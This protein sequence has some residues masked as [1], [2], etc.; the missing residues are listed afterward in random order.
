M[1]LEP[2]PSRLLT[3]ALRAGNAHPGVCR[4]VEWSCAGGCE[5]VSFL[6]LQGLGSRDWKSPLRGKWCLWTQRNTWTWQ[7]VTFPKRHFELPVLK[8]NYFLVVTSISFPWNTVKG[9]PAAPREHL[10][11]LCERESAQSSSW[12][13][14]SANETRRLVWL[15][16][17]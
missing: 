2:S 5:G 14:K 11:C 15:L 4:Q 8:S 9:P 7:E 3:A 16:R 10:C 17:K 12:T 13:Q 1:S 6:P